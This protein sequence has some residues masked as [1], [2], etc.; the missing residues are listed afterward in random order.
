LA[1]HPSRNRISFS[2]SNTLP[3]IRRHIKLSDSLH[4][5]LISKFTQYVPYLLDASLAR[6]QIDSS[7]AASGGRVD[8]CSSSLSRSLP[9]NRFQT[10]ITAVA[11]HEPDR[12]YIARTSR[13]QVPGSQ[14]SESEESSARSSSVPESSGSFATR[15]YL[16][17]TRNPNKAPER[18]DTSESRIRHY[19]PQI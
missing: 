17:T 3:I 5:Q 1:E 12:S 19:E 13:I 2:T 18:V 11:V 16:S 6:V 4:Q 14:F 9:N 8:L 15:F 7:S 10:T